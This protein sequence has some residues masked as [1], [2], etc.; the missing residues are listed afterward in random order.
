M[1]S[2][3]SQQ[4]ASLS[5]A[6][7]LASISA[8]SSTSFGSST[9]AAT[10]ASSAPALPISAKASLIDA[11]I[12]ALK[13]RIEQTITS[14][15]AQL[16]ERAA[17]TRSVDHDLNQLW[18]SINQ[19]SSRLVTV[20][21]QL[22]PTALA[23]HD[24][25]AQSSKQG[26]LISVLSD[27]LAA[28]RHLER[29]EKLLHQSDFPALRAELPKAAEVLQPLRSRSALQNL[30][31]VVELRARFD[32][33]ENMCKEAD[34]A[35]RS[36]V[37][38]QATQQAPLRSSLDET[39][40]DQKN[41]VSIDT[42]QALS[43]ALKV[44]DTARALIVARGSE[45]GWKEVR[46]EL[47]APAPHPSAVTPAASAIVQPSV[48][49]NRSSLDIRPERMFREDLAPESA[50]LTRNSSSSSNTNARNRH[51]PKLG[52]R[53]IRPQDQLGSGP[54]NAEDTPLDEDGWGLDED[55]EE[56][57]VPAPAQAMSSSHPAHYGSHG[58]SSSSQPAHPSVSALARDSRH[59]SPSSSVIMQSSMSSSSSQRSAFAVQEPEPRVGA[60]AS[61]GVDAW[62]LG[63]EDDKAE[64]EAEA[65][66]WDLDEDDAP[67]LLP[68]SPKK[69]KTH[70]PASVERADTHAL[71]AAP[72]APD[73]WGLEDEDV[74]ASED[75][76]EI[77]DEHK[78]VAAEPAASQE[79]LVA[80]R[81]V[82][83]SMHDAAF[84]LAA[85]PANKAELSHPQAASA[86]T[87]NAPED[88]WETEQQ[89]E[90]ATAPS[91]VFRP[92][93][94]LKS[95]VS[96]SEAAGPPI[97][98]LANSAEASQPKALTVPTTNV[99]SDP[100]E[101]DD[102][103]EEFAPSVTSQMQEGADL[104]PPVLAICPPHPDFA[105]AWERDH[106][107][108]EAVAH[109]AA[110]SSIHPTHAAGQISAPV[111]AVN[112]EA[113]LPQAELGP[114]LAQMVSSHDVMEVLQQPLHNMEE[115]THAGHE[116][117]VSHQT[118]SLTNKP[119]SQ[120][121][122]AD[123]TPQP[124]AQQAAQP[125]EDEMELEPEEDAWGF[126]E[127]SS[128]SE[129]D[130]AEFAPI[131][132]LSKKDASDKPIATAGHAEFSDGGSTKADTAKAPTEFPDTIKSILTDIAAPKAHQPQPI[133]SPP[134]PTGWGQDFSDSDSTG[135]PATSSALSNA[136]ERSISSSRS[137]S[138]NSKAR[139]GTPTREAVKL[140]DPSPKPAAVVKEECTISQRSLDLVNLAEST[141][142]SVISLLRGQV[143]SGSCADDAEALAGAIFKIFELHRALM[144]VAHGEALRDVPSLAMQFFND[145]E[146]LAR[147][148][149]RLVADKGEEIS[150]AWIS[151]DAEGAKR[152]KTKELPKLEQEAAQTRGLGQRWFEAQMTAQTKIL[153]DTLME[154]DGFARTF[155]EHR[156][157]R[158]ERCVKQ[159]VQT[160]QQLAKAWQPVL[161]ASR[162]H[163][164]IGRLV[165]LVFQKV[166]H[167]VLDLEDIGESESEKIASLVRTLGSL[168][169]LFS[170]EGDA[171]Q[172]AAPL[173]VPSWFKTSY[174]IEILTGSL[175]D[176]EFLAFEAGALVDYSRKELAGLIKALFADT[177]N[178]SKL[179]RRIE[180]APVD[181]LAH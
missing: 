122:Q 106:Q 80:T 134:S 115:A 156:F 11:Q 144:P 44:L 116:K 98:T 52:A 129:A 86:S 82:S 87:S 32:R 172:S 15:A 74:G 10:A 114:T 81:P 75:P 19:T 167:D 64:V 70:V 95:S 43:P 151:H 155:D 53:V 38:V 55:E 105:D 133:A 59:S 91:P 176:I 3:T 9:S 166:L 49:S 7:F 180:S 96:A 85:D 71:P 164:A 159:V 157:A 8:E 30:P 42:A 148:L 90:P 121:Q 23:Y 37:T 29:L 149:A 89:A 94:V 60:S 118:E 165:D 103:S 51:K 178:R 110:P 113:S 179:L 126:D 158:C 83:S 12:D 40:K 131:T 120:A 26:L 62:G 125:A 21:P 35:S 99:K 150:T 69:E 177:P 57:A 46:I 58:S 97:T 132:P 66:A 63:E 124:A 130:R 31:A 72:A 135:D 34:S 108:G 146:Y 92:Q 88:P 45:A 161:V 56:P 163:A 111:L 128:A 33:L 24:A 142:D 104:P 61:N 65:D 13:G 77:Q 73:A 68:P 36:F 168:E 16:R 154:A 140:P 175:V 14:H 22:A 93:L 100:W 28:I 48:D 78:K 152:W 139:S 127:G 147:E 169:S 6:S 76:W 119:P 39:A 107:A 2:T 109:D 50:S 162:F 171:E 117:E 1:S 153:L 137:V 136:R 18:R 101:T 138:V 27:L 20:G 145:C 123:I 84:V 170:V 25:L 141:M 112:P 173:W 17:S 4:D 67:A 41:T 174:L 54:F 181:V 102:H 47:D 5:A 79:D 143:H 160:L